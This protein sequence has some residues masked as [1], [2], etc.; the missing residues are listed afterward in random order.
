M[1]PQ[2]KERL[3]IRRHKRVRSKVS[4]TPERPRLSVSR[5]INNI[6]AQII[7]DE[8]GVTLASAGTLDKTLR[9]SL[10]SGGSVEAA[11]EVGR[12]VASRALEAGITAVVYDRGGNLYHGRVKA[13]A[14]GAREGGLSL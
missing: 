14:E 5:S 2:E 8:R 13:L 11:R 10:A 12:L 9:T 6:Y 7:D 1:K 4:G 3:R